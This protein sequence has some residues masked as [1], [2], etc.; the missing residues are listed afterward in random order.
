MTRLALIH[1]PALS[2]VVWRPL[3]SVLR[4]AGHEVALPD[5]TGQ[6]EVAASW[7]RRATLTCVLAIDDLVGTAPPAGNAREGSRDY[8]AVAPGPDV[9][10]AYSGAGVLMPLVA[11]ARP[12]RRAVFLDA[13]VPASER[14]TVPSEQVRAFAAALRDQHGADRL[15]PWTRWW[16]REGI[17]ELLPDVDLR[18]ELDR[19]APRLPVDF[20]DEA[21]GV[22]PGWE[23]EHIDYV[24]LSD[25]YDADA[26]QARARGW[27]V[28]RLQA[29]HLAV[30]TRPGDI[31]TVL[32]LDA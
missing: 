29:D 5:Y 28:H 4:A 23:P 13:V 3:V 2:P 8:P 10:V 32:D 20:Y 30:A 27:T 9:L 31:V 6:L 22:A 19:T 1:P 7:W 24:Q 25:A 16:G 18:D 11:N 12:P 15:P 14:H 21:V 17:A 26:T